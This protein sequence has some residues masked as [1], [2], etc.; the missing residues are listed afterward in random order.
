MEGQTDS[1]LHRRIRKAAH[2]VHTPLTSIAGFAEL[3]VEDTSLSA[4]AKDSAQTILD[5]ARRLS[6]LLDEFF[7][8]VS[9]KTE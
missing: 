4:A 9:P 5:E 7:D 8:E 1:E 3:L 2:D 6:S